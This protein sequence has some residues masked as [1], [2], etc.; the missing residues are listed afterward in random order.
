MADNINR[1]SEIHGCDPSRLK[2]DQYLCRV[3]YV[4]VKEISGNSV[5]VENQFG[6]SWVIWKQIIAQEMVSA[7]Q[8]DEEKKVP[9]MEI[10]RIL[11]NARDT[12]FSVGFRKKIDCLESVTL[13]DLETPPKR[14]TLAKEF[15]HRVLVGYLY[16][17]E[18]EME[19][20]V[21]IDLEIEDEN[22]EAKKCFVDH[23]TIEW[24][25]FNKVKY[26]A[27]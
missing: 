7:H 27:K 8:V 9:R 10:V 13:E 20:S 18:P 22:F 15:T 21:V 16:Q 5:I 6:F 26:I 23:S 14:K 2:V 1:G 11:Q 19:R 12:I 4:K 25:I 24:L 3:S 17:E